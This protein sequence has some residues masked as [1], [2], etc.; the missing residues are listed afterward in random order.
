VANATLQTKIDQYIEY[1][2]TERVHLGLEL[3]TPV[4]MLQRS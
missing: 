1:Y 2:N 3:Q 4:S